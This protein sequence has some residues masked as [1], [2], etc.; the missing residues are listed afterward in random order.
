MKTGDKG[1]AI[2]ITGLPVTNFSTPQDS[3]KTDTTGN[4][5]KS[6]PNGSNP[7]APV[8]TDDVTITRD[9]ENLRM[10]EISISKQSEIDHERVSQLKLAIES[11][12]YNIDSQRVAEKFV[13]LETQLSV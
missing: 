9:A 1:M 3:G 8:V 2:E 11:G 10:I 6:V 4:S 5:A 12:S 13:Q 7:A